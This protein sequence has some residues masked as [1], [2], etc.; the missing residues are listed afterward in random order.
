MTGYGR[1]VKDTPLGKIIVQIQSLNRKMLDVN[2]KVPKDFFSLEI[3]V[4]RWIS[5]VIFRGQVT[6]CVEF[7]QEDPLVVQLPRLQALKTSWEKVAETLGFDP[8]KAIDFSFLVEKASSYRESSLL[9]VST[10]VSAGLK[11]AVFAALEEIVAM[12]TREGEALVADITYRLSLMEDS[13]EQIEA[14][15]SNA[16]EKQRHKLQ[17]R[18]K[19]FSLQGAEVDE[20]LTREIVLY[21]E[22]LDITEE[23][24]RLRSHIAQFRALLVTAEKSVG[25]TMDFLTQELN[26]EANTIAAKS[27]DDQLS[28]LAVGIKSEIEKIREQVQNIE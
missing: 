5:E 21:A 6:V 11:E 13:L 17:E 12:K 18:M 24:T 7:V 23:K 10:E 25:K 15:S 27:A 4:K 22:K 3:E 19:E 28:W 16:L 2:L 14:R 9:G 8:Q 20:R 1:S 26:R